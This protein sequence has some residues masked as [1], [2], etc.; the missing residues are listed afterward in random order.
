MRSKNDKEQTESSDAPSATKTKAKGTDTL[1]I[2]K[3]ARKN[4][5]VSIKV[6]GVEILFPPPQEPALESQPYTLPS[7]E[8]PRGSGIPPNLRGMMEATSFGS[9]TPKKATPAINSISDHPDVYARDLDAWANQTP[10]P[11]R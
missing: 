3:W 4:G 10:L 6:E 1:K 9:D 8:P 2:C 7:M 11:R 5:A